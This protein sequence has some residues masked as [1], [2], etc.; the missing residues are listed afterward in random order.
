MAISDA[1]ER[2]WGIAWVTLENDEII[3]IKL[4]GTTPA[5]EDGEDVFDAVGRQ[6]FALKGEEY[7]WEPYQEAKEVIAEDIVASQSP[8]VDT[9]TEATGAS[10]QWMQAVERAL[11][12]ARSS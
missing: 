11:E 2:G 3:G 12:A 1:T 10:N 4:E 5:Q 8:D 9:Y 7:P 6:V